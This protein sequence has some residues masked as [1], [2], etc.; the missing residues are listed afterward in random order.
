MS[1]SLRETWQRLKQA[2]VET[3]TQLKSAL[4]SIKGRSIEL[5]AMPDEGA[6]PDPIGEELLIAWLLRQKLLEPG[7]KL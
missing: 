5:V 6:F 1:A 4:K 2:S 3:A 7:E